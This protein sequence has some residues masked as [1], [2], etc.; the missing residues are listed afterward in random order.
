VTAFPGG[1][2]RLRAKL[3]CQVVAQARQQRPTMQPSADPGG[4][5]KRQA[6]ELGGSLRGAVVGACSGFERQADR[7]RAGS[8][9]RSQ[10]NDA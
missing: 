6:E 10:H 9:R 4:L 8:S 5:S 3:A 2:I 7:R 1:L